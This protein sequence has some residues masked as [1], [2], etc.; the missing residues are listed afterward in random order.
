MDN[1]KTYDF[2][3]HSWIGECMELFGIANDVGNVLQKS[4]IQWKPALTSNGQEFGDRSLKKG[5]GASLSAL[6]L[7]VSVV[8][9]SQSM[10]V[11]DWFNSIYLLFVVDY[12]L[13]GK[14]GEQRD[15]LIK[16]VHVSRQ[17]L[18][19]NLNTKI[20]LSSLWEE[21]CWV[22]CYRTPGCKNYKGRKTRGVHL[23]ILELGRAKQSQMKVMEVYKRKH[24]LILKSLLNKRGKPSTMNTC[25]VLF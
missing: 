2:L 16:N 5:K 8:T 1:R 18:N 24:W 7:L 10:P 22:R 13:C 17:E 20:D 14:I 19:W 9:L 23:G 15:S 4:M 21:N 3:F 11:I 25:A 6:L 12:K